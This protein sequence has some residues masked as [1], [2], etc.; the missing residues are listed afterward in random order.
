MRVLDTSVIYKWYV[1]EEDT[2]QAISLRNDFTKRGIEIVIPDF[3]FHELANALRYNPRIDREEVE[4]II[5]NLY[6][7]NLE[8]VMITP[9]LTKESLKFAYNNQISVYDAI[10]LALAQNLE[11][12]FITADRKLYEKTKEL[13][14]V[15]FLRDIE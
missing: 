9:T 8:V 2:I 13:R 12:E 1:E 15:K 7:L 3:L 4:R 14:F 5:E 6:E 10:Y 11:V